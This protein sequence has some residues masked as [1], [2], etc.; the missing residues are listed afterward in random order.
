MK[1]IYT[2]MTVQLKLHELGQVCGLPT[3][4]PQMSVSNIHKLVKTDKSQDI[5]D[6]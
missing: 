2:K 4:L 3:Y 5:V 6:M 1:C